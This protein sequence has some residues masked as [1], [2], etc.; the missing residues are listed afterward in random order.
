[1]LP[2]V[3]AGAVIVW[4]DEALLLKDARESKGDIAGKDKGGETKVNV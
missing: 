2:D 4:T 3:G 1:M